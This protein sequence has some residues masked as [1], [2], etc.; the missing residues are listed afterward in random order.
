HETE[1]H[2]VLLNFGALKDFKP[3]TDFVTGFLAA[4]GVETTWS[5]AFATVDEGVKW[6]NENEFDYGVICASAKET[7]AFVD[8][9]LEHF[10]GNKQIDVAGKYEEQM[11]QRWQEKGLKGSVY[12]GQDQLE[13]LHALKSLFEKEGR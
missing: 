3:R 8:A 1:H 11:M 6:V 4:G 5:P 9:F 7:E 10:P 12:K 2:V 13:K